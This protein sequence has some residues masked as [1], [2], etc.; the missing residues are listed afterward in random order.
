MRQTVIITDT[1][2]ET[3]LVTQFEVASIQVSNPTLSPIAFRQGGTDF[4]TIN[5]ADFVIPAQSL[6][7]IPALGTQF[8]FQFT[9]VSILQKSNIKSA[10]ITGLSINEA[11]TGIGSIQPVAR[12]QFYENERH[13]TYGSPPDDGSGSVGFFTF[14]NNI[15]N[16][17]S[18]DF[19]ATLAEYTVPLQRKFFISSIYLYL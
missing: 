19:Q 5:S 7:R 10:K 17:R 8:A 12:P 11:S 1:K 2:P 4:P 14:S 15:S 6:L 13:P 18:T 9:S 16:D 3:E